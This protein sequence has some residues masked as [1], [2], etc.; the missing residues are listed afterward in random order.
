MTAGIA[1]MADGVYAFASAREHAWHRLGTVLDEEMTAEQALITAHLAGWN[2]RKINVSARDV[3]VSSGGTGPVRISVPDRFAT[4]YT[5]PVTGKA[6]YLGVVG[7]H[8]Q[9]F[10]NE[11]TTDFLDALTHEAG[12]HFETAGALFDGKRVFVSVKMPNT[13]QLAGG[14]DQIDLYI[15]A[16]NWHDGQGSFE[17]H[18]TPIRPV[19]ANTVA[20][21]I[22]AAKSSFRIRHTRGSQTVALQEAQRVL[23]LTFKYEEA[24]QKEAEAMIAKS[25]TD[26]EFFDIVQ[27]LLAGDDKAPS[28]RKQNSIDAAMQNI[29]AVWAG[30]TGTMAG[31]EDTAWGGYQ[32]FIEYTDHLQPVR[33]ADDAGV[34]RAQRA[35][36]NAVTVGLKQNA[37]SAFAAV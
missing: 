32:A 23:G 25:I 11:W 15:M 26:N 7:T 21:A 33:A 14:Q 28:T 13:M 4:V 27:G 19:C 18:V 16:T 8:Y 12:A 2:V 30:E 3:A 34:A 22:S 6:Q 9:P 35:V 24:F 37:W 31:I 5:N 1:E 20:A 17:A 10:Q 29:M 36:T